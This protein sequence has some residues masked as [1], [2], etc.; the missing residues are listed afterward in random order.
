MEGL[1]SGATALFAWPLFS[2]TARLSLAARQC[3]LSVSVS[4]IHT[5]DALPVCKH[6]TRWQAPVLLVHQTVPPAPLLGPTGSC[7]GL[8]QAA[9]ARAEILSDPTSGV[10]LF[11]PDNDGINQTLSDLGLKLEGLLQDPKLVLSI[12]QFHVLPSPVEARQPRQLGLVQ[13]CEGSPKSELG[14]SCCHAAVRPERALVFVTTVGATAGGWP[15]LHAAVTDV[16]QAGLDYAPTGSPNSV[17]RLQA[18]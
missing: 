11:A 13:R 17:L 4:S 14:H 18:T 15:R 3:C 2:R 7:W 9:R 6:V 5:T 1:P 12:L 10:T 16:L 8:K